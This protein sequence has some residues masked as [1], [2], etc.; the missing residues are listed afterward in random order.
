MPDSDVLENTFGLNLYS[1]DLSIN[2]EVTIYE[3]LNEENSDRFEYIFPKFDLVKKIENKTNFNGDFSFK[4]QGIVR[5]YD[6]N[7]HEKININDFIF[8]SNPSITKNGFYNNFNLILKNSNT[9]TQKSSKFKEGEN[10]YISSLFN[11]I[12]RY[13]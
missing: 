13:H 8:N 4:S 11:S 6:T 7:I 5:N 2:T 1:N 9:D 12:L 10:Y 3:N